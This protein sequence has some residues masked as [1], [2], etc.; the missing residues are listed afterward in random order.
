MHLNSE[1]R[2]S[3]AQQSITGRKARNEDCLG[4]FMP[5]GNLLTTKGACGMIADGVSTAEA[6]A[7]AAE[8]CVREFINDYFDTPD[9]WTVKKSAQKVWFW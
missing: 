4:F 3:T 7:E 6:G 1:I 9:I 2:L 8:Y 5:V